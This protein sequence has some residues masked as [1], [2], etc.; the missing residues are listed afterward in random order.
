MKVE[1]DLYSAFILEQDPMNFRKVTIR[2][3]HVARRRGSKRTCR[4]ER[5]HRFKNRGLTG[6]V[7]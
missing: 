5:V 7:G 3:D 2:A 6:A 1:V 4:R